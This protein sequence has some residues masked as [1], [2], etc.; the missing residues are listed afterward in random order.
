MAFKLIKTKTFVHPCTLI[1]LDE[2]GK[3]HTGKLRVRFNAIPRAEW[4]ELTRN[5]D[6]DDDRLIYDVLVNKIE[7]DID[8]GA[9]GVLPAEAA[10]KAL[11]DNLSLTTQVV[12]QGMEALFGAAAKNVRRSRGR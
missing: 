12:D 4:D 11:R 1:Q 8:D 9:G 5:A 10:V 3:Q 6:P 7:D 2:E